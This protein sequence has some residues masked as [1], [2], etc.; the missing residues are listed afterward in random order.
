M[1]EFS[2][3]NSKIKTPR[4]C[5]GVFKRSLIL[6]S[7]RF[8]KIESCSKLRGRNEMRPRNQYARFVRASAQVHKRVFERKLEDKNA[9]AISVRIFKRVAR[10]LFS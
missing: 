1:S 8:F 10:L 6:N 5:S 9:H 2:Q 7:E 4:Y 3:E